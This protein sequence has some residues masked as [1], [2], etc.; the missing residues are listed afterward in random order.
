M[1]CWNLS[2]SYPSL[3]PISFANLH[4]V[5]PSST[6]QR[7]L[8]HVLSVGTVTRDEAERHE[9]A[10]KAGLF[11]FRVISGSG[12]LEFAGKSL[13]LKP[14]PRCWLIDLRQSRAY[15]PAKGKTLVTA[16]IRFAGLGME[17]WREM[18][19]SEIA[20]HLK[21]IAEWKLL[22]Q[23]QQRILNLVRRRPSGYE[24]QVHRQLDEILGMLLR[25]RGSLHPR[26]AALPEPVKL[27]LRAV[28]EDPAR[29]WQAKELS[30]IAA[31]SYSALR[32]LFREFQ[33]ESIHEFLQRTRLDQARL[34][35][36]DRRLS[37]KQVADNLHFSSAVYFSHFFRRATGMTP[38]EF[39]QN[40]WG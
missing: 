29:D 16:G 10:D 28:L 35:L 6:A 34:L 40:A 17:V 33:E 20:F 26:G 24:W 22:R 14:G 32:A 5:E 27:V 1:L 2:R 8:W 13:E 3:M 21:E 9:G 31:V 18:L 19:G 38:G 23:S 4:F 15:V 36:C 37:I 7:L 25:V 11:L 12:K 39:R 30:A